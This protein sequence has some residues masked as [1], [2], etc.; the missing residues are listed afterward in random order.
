MEIAI[1]VVIMYNPNVFP[2]I[3]DSFARSLRFDTPLI[4]EAM[5]SGMAISFKRL[6]KMVPKGFI[7]F[8]MKL[9][10][11]RKMEITPSSIPPNIP[12]KMRR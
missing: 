7:Q 3:R 8:M 10:H 2:P 11:A 9:S 6:I 1:T 4:R 5:I 12:M